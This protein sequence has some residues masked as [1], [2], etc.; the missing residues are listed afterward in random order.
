M[1]AL[2]VAITGA[3][4]Y[5]GMHVAHRLLDR[6]D[7]VLSL[8]NQPVPAQDPFNGKVKA[9]PFDFT[10]GRLAERLA[11]VDVLACAY[12]TRH[13][14]PPIGHSGPWMSHAQ[15]TERSKIIIREAK[16]A[17]VKRLVWTS[18]ANPGLDPD[19]PYYDGK[20]KV[21][22][23][24]RGSGLPYAILRPACF[25]G[26]GGILVENVVW[27]VRRLPIF[28]LPS[29]PASFYVRP[30]HVADYAETVAQA[31]HSQRVFVKDAT[32]P[33][34]VDF[35]DLIGFTSKVIG[36]R[37]RVIYLPLRACQALYAIASRLM[38]ETILTL[39]EL[40]GLSRNRLDSLED[41]TGTVSLFDYIRTN[42]TD[43]GKKFL[44]E[45]VR[46]S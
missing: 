12:W 37:T 8:T 38:G 44:R 14:R 39:D 15:A 46:R 3:W 4:S 18:I 6:G 20:A 23:A 41:P 36:T 22:E 17:G 27:A 21:E 29:S 2:T 16:A 40:K 30:I 32:G 7:T 33:D 42:A 26:P 45:P 1:T 31:V 24:V 11:G 34:R 10:P 13:N 35:A 43:L 9:V 25:F 5:S 19:L 28:P